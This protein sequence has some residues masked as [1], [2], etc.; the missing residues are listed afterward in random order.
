MHQKAPETDFQKWLVDLFDKLHSLTENNHI[1]K[2]NF[3]EYGFQKIGKNFSYPVSEKFT[4]SKNLT[5]TCEEEIDEN[6]NISE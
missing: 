5:K 6:T 2:S 4:T 3:I 1:P